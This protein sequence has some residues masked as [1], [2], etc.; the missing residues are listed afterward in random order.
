MCHHNSCNFTHVDLKENLQFVNTSFAHTTVIIDNCITNAYHC[1][2]HLPQQKH[3]GELCCHHSHPSGIAAGSGVSVCS[4]PISS[5]FSPCIGCEEDSTGA[6]VVRG[7]NNSSSSPK[8]SK[9]AGAENDSL[10]ILIEN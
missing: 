4:T 9:S 6:V 3:D 8:G 5:L 10:R 2:T 1:Q 7:R